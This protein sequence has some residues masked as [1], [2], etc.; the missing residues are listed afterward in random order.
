[1]DG[2]AQVWGPEDRVGTVR[3]LATA[4]A[5]EITLT[6][7]VDAELGEELDAAARVVHEYGLPVRMDAT[8]VTFMDS[9]GVRLIARCYANGPVTVTASPTV[10]FL[11]EI[12]A[13]DDVLAAPQ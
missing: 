11:L 4:E 10:R 7:E 13:M 3:V 2:V 12:L 9:T 8:D 1:M 5:V 6:G